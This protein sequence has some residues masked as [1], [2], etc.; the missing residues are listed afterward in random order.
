MTV[1]PSTRSSFATCLEQNLR[2]TVS[3]IPIE[4]NHIL[5]DILAVG[6]LDV[7]IVSWHPNGANV[8]SSFFAGGFKN[9]NQVLIKVEEG[10]NCASFRIHES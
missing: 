2:G 7:G 1:M 3:L 4:K 6:N 8:S 9:L 10:I 5:V